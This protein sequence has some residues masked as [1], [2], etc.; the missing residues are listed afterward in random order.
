MSDRPARAPMRRVHTPTVLQMEAVEC[1]AAALSS[2]LA[3]YGRRVSL[4]ELRLACGVSRDGTNAGNMVKAARGFGLIA[5][6]YTRE[7][8]D[9]PFLPLP[10]VVFWNFNH[11]VVVEGFGRGRVYLNDPAVGPRVVTDAEFR[12][13]FTGVVLTFEPGP[14]FQRGGDR[15]GLVRPLRQ[16]LKGSE[17]GLLYVVL[18]SLALALPGLV[19]PVFSRIFVDSYLEAGVGGWVYPLIIGLALT[20]ALRALLTWM[21]QRYLLRLETKLALTSSFRFF[22]HVLRLPVEFFTQRYGGEVGS[23]VEMNDRVAQLLSRELAANLLN[24]LMCVLY[25]A[26]M[27][28]Y[29]IPL[30]LVGVAVAGLNILALRWVSRRRRDVNMRLLQERAKLMGASMSGLQTI[31][32]LKATASESDFF[33]QWAGHLAKVT[34]ADQRMGVYTLALGAAPALLAAVNT[35]AIL[36][37]GALRVMDGALT[38]GMLV[39]IQSLMMSFLDPVEQLV[40]LGGS[41]QEI[42]G[43]LSRLDDVLRYPPDANLEQ[44][45]QLDP[46]GTLTLLR[47]TPVERGKRMGAPIKLAGQLELRNVTFG[48][49][50]LA[51]P[52]ITDF[53]LTVQPGARVALVGLTASGKSTVA[54]LISGLYRP[55]SGE[56]LLDGRPRGSLPRAAVVNSLAM[57]DQDFFLCEGTVREVLTL[58]DPTISLEDV[59]QAA[60]DACIHDDVVARPGG[61]ESKVEEG[62]VNF[63]GGQRQRLEI[64][65]ALTAAPTLLVLDEATSALDP[66]VEQR[67]DD[68]LR[69]RGCTCVL[70]A[71]RL[72]TIRDCDEIIVLDH[73]KIVQRG[74]HET[75]NAVDGLYRRLIADQ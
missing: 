57:V 3:Y 25:V 64:A 70:V 65:R 37:I 67:I 72:S 33:S 40:G 4:E 24:V 71:H 53:N 21:Q 73:G 26:L 5:K 46:A 51:P 63:S 50:R 15:P 47:L 17:G 16:R 60:R 31:E 2:V 32:T 43:E 42:E 41:L 75:L 49:A 39:A 28:F 9:L 23:R 69:R 74:T 61:Y 34:S 36:G 38:V 55:W 59:V 18:V 11:F 54:K 68:N 58:W 44:E 27:A 48:Y 22:R 45:E 62:G 56:V 7:V 29:D 8:A 12:E 19:I 35:A 13:A 14:E 6:G 1:G 20:A 66:V 52:L 10:L 30:T